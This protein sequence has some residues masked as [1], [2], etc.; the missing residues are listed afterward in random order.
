MVQWRISRGIK[1]QT[2][3]FLDGFNEVVPLQWLQY[4]DERE[5]EVGNFG[6]QCLFG[7][8]PCVV[9]TLLRWDIVFHLFLVVDCFRFIGLLCFLCAQLMLC[10]MQEFD[11]DDWMRHSVYRG[12]TRNSKQVQWFW[13]V[14]GNHMSHH[15]L[16]HTHALL[17][18]LFS[19]VVYFTMLVLAPLSASLFQVVKSIDNERR[20]RLLQF[21]TGTCRLPIGGFAELVGGLKLV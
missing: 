14:G 13:Q 5:L 9:V 10:G 2:K 19:L 20:A 8:I 18:Y 17:M 15:T 1:D 3:A 7:G 4:F 6:I 16:T 12:Y 11:V 21:I